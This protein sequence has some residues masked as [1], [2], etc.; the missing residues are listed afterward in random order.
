MSVG[1]GAASPIRWDR[2]QARPAKPLSRQAALC[3]LCVLALIVVG[4]A[5]RRMQLDIDA[6][7]LTLPRVAVVA[8]ESWLG[9]LFIIL[10]AARCRPATG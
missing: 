8:I 3:T 9:L 6:Y 1:Y 10:A 5:L 7:G 4:S 2:W